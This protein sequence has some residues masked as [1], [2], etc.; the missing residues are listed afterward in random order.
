MKVHIPGNNQVYHILTERSHFIFLAT[1]QQS[2]KLNIPTLK[3][4]ITL[5]N[6]KSK[7][8]IYGQY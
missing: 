6:Y 4:V 7:L 5:Q 3:N 1:K 2:L 8:T